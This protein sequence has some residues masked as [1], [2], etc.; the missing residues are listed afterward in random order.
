MCYTVL[1]LFLGFS[2]LFEAN[3]G[4]CE[5]GR[6][7]GFCENV[8]D[9]FLLHANH[10][11]TSLRYWHGHHHYSIFLE[12]TPVASSAAKRK[13]QKEQNSEWIHTDGEIGERKVV[14]CTVRWR[15]C[16]YYLWI[17]RPTGPLACL[18]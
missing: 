14:A 8:D 10:E 9:L 16:R 15:S 6:G 13:F 12:A 4:H 5:R 2:A 7:R 17:R 18:R 11:H 3:V 1:R